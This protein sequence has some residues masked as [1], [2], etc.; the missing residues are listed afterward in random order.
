M[1]GGYR[2]NAGRPKGTGKRLGPKRPKI[3]PEVSQEATPVV[4]PPGGVLP[5]DY[6]LA[7]LNDPQA[8]PQLRARF[9]IAAAPYCH[10][11][12][13]DSRLGKK[14]QQDQAATDA[15]NGNSAWGTDLQFEGRAAN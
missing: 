15:S 10:P 14:D 4:L 8:D 3:V 7:I 12:I 11:R 13:A 6:M 2:P 9:A 1:S 5:L